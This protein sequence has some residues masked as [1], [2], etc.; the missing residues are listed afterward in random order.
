MQRRACEGSENGLGI[1]RPLN[2]SNAQNI[3]R[4]KIACPQ[5][6][7]NMTLIAAAGQCP[8]SRR[9]GYAEMCYSYEKIYYAIATVLL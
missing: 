6:E 3:L 2:K 5:L 7:L 4:R 9:A 1:T 8:S